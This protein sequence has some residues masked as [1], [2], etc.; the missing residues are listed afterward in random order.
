MSK[1]EL[2]VKLEADGFVSTDTEKMPIGVRVEA[3]RV[4][5]PRGFGGV[6]LRTDYIGVSAI[7]IE[8][9]S[10]TDLTNNDKRLG[11]SDFM[12]WKHADGAG[13]E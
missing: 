10:Y 13:D 8:E 6:I 9:F 11:F 3:V 12:A 5:Q 1:S 2:M 4:Y 7:R